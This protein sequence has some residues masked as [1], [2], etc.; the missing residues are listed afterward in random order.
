MIANL[1][2]L[3]NKKKVNK[4]AKNLSLMQDDTKKY[5]HLKINKLA[6]ILVIIGIASFTAGLT[7]KNIT[8]D[9]EYAKGVRDLYL[10]NQAAFAV[11]IDQQEGI[12]IINGTQL[13][14]I[15]DSPQGQKFIDFSL[16]KSYSTQAINGTLLLY[17]EQINMPEVVVE[18]MKEYRESTDYYIFQDMP[19]NRLLL[20]RTG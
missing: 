5:M 16:D 8:S 13:T 9:D 12:G 10:G 20:T 2:N 14:F 19:G 11:L 1:K 15:Y 4:E 7:V 6:F 3:A 17:R 18:Y